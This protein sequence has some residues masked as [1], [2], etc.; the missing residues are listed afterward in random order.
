MEMTV[1]GGVTK[2]NGVGEVLVAGGST[3]KRVDS[4]TPTYSAWPLSPTIC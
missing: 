4:M 2:S 3:L 1:C